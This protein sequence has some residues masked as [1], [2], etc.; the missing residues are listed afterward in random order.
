MKQRYLLGRFAAVA[1]LAAAAQ[2]QTS[3]VTTI[4]TSPSGAQYS[5]DGQNYT[6]PVSAVWP[7]GS[8]HVLSA[9]PSQVNP[10]FGRSMTFN[11]WAWAGG[12]FQQPVYYHSRPGDHLLYG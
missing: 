6:Q 7:Q 5:V 4:G 8:K 11:S 3:S 1:A 10:A 2:A 9:I 12:S